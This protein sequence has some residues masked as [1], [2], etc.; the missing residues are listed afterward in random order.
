M[1]QQ[2]SVHP[3]FLVTQEHTLLLL[4]EPSLKSVVNVK[5]AHTPTDQ[6]VAGAINAGPARGSRIRDRPDVSYVVLES[7]PL[8][9][10]RPATVWPVMLANFPLKDIVTAIYV[11][12]ERTQL[13]WELSMIQHVYL[14][15]LE[16]TPY[17]Q[18][19]HPADIVRLDLS[20]QRLVQ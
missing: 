20:P 3:V 9:L 1:T 19:L 5:P 6:A 11:M 12:Q 18:E 16:C 17:Q 4:E 10:E 15:K 13:S 7:T 14:V 2:V 8:C